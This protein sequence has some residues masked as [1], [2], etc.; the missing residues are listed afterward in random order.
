MKTDSLLSMKEKKDWQAL[1]IIPLVFI[2]LDYGN[3]K[4]LYQDY[5]KIRSKRYNVILNKGSIANSVENLMQ[6]QKHVPTSETFQTTYD[7]YYQKPTQHAYKILNFSQK[8]NISPFP[9]SFN[10][11]KYNA[12]FRSNSVQYDP[13]KINTSFN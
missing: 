11:N 8:K 4:P 3:Y 12:P 13:S 10:Y 2:I 7:Y 1:I 9:D 6:Y 5:G